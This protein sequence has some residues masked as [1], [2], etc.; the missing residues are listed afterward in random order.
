M[1]CVLCVFLSL[2]VYNCGLYIRAAIRLGGGGDD[3]KVS[4]KG[5]GGKL[6]YSRTL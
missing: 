2:F 1:L 3:V 5:Y 6:Q 4:T